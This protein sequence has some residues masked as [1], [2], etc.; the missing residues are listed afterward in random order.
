MEV[1]V[2]TRHCEVPST[3]VRLASRQVR[4]LARYNPQIS[5]A[6]VVFFEEKRHRYVEVV[7]RIHKAPTVVAKGEARDFRSAVDD[8]V[9][10]LGRI[11]RRQ[12]ERARD[13]RAEGL[14]GVLRD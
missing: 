13:H 14:P 4:K 12:R 1:S 11:L 2:T 10:R 5:S 9:A 7:V 6:E 3:M 8:V